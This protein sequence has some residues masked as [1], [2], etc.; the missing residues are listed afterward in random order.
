MSPFTTIYRSMK[1]TGMCYDYAMAA[2]Y[3][4]GINDKD[5]MDILVL[6]MGTGTYATQCERYFENDF[7]FMGKTE[8]EISLVCLTEDVP[9]QTIERE[10]GWKGF[11]VQA[12]LDFSLVGILSKISGIL[13]EKSISIF[14]VSTYNTDYILVKADDFYRAMEILSVEGYKIV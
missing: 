4:A 14:A 5:E 2:P 6:G 11:R 13:A 7:F 9:E 12:I 10:D 8:E 3:M 1:M